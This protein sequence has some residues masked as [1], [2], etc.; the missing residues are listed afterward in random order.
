[1]ADEARAF[2]LTI[3]ERDGEA[4]IGAV[5]DNE[6]EIEVDFPS[7]DEEIGEFVVDHPDATLMHGSLPPPRQRRQPSRHPHAADPD[8]V[9]RSHPH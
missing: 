5:R 6:M 3:V 9:V 7:S 4:V 2:L 1:L 8:G